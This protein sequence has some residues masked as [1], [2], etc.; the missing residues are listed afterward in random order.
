MT[1]Q[2]LLRAY[3]FSL[4]LATASRGAVSTLLLMMFLGPIPHATAASASTLTF[5]TIDVPGATSSEVD[6][7]NAAGQMVG[8]YIDSGGKGHGFLL[9]KGVFTNIDFPGAATFTE[10]I[11]INAQGQ[12]SG[13]YDVASG[14]QH[15]FLLDKGT[16]TTI[17]PP[18]S[19]F[20]QAL[21]INDAGQIVGRYRS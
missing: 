17:D 2:N 13:I 11:G 20:T 15:G 21:G 8:I 10:A 12:I 6:G 7:I 4:T 16:F 19:T 3:P 9:D 1:K 14:T 18:G 5:S